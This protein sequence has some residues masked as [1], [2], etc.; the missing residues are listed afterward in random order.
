MALPS[1]L[2]VIGHQFILVL[3]FLGFRRNERLSGLG[4]RPDRAGKRRPVMACGSHSQLHAK[5]RHGII[6]YGFG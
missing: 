2:G 6:N 3:P 5:L 4:T 1:G